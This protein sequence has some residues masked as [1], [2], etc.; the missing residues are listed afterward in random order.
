M[1]KLQIIRNFKVVAAPNNRQPT[2]RETDLGVIFLESQDGQDWYECQA[3]FSDDTVK[4]MYDSTGVIM[5]VVDKPVPQRGN[6]YAVSML[7][8]VEMSVAEVA[9]EDY[10][11]DCQ[12]DG[13]WVFDG[14]KIIPRPIPQSELVAQ[15]K[16]TRAQLMAEANQKIA[17]LQDASDL[18][19]A[20]EDELAQ[21]KAW[22][23]Y[24]VLLSRVDISS[25]PEIVWPSLPA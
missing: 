17:P 9:L 25:A 10:P 2:K 18:D 15:A 4:I 8:P 3:S 12:A 16:A 22:K 19:I 5:A 14:K 23:T 1:T 11:A 21:L 20:T 13:N 6:V 24:R 7:W